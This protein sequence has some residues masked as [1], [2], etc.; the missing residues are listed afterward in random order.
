MVDGEPEQPDDQVPMDVVMR[1][2]V[3]DDDRTTAYAMRLLATR[4]KS[5]RIVIDCEPTLYSCEPVAQCA[6][7]NIEP[8]GCSP[9]HCDPVATRDPL[10]G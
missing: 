4:T 10:S 2:D 5:G 9:L 8:P 3:K 1:D 7:F 6:N